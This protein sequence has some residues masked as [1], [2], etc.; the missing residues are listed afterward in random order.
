MIR[1]RKDNDHDNSILIKKGELNT[2]SPGLKYFLYEDE[3]GS[4]YGET[5]CATFDIAKTREEYEKLSQERLEN[6]IYCGEM[7]IA[8]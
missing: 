4:I 8:R 7:T 6:I 5:L 2:L 1:P 3:D